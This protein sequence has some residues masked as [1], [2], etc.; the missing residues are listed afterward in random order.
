MQLQRLEQGGAQLLLQL[1]ADR[2]QH[3]VRRL[4]LGHPQMPRGADGV[5]DIVVG[6]HQHAR[7]RDRPSS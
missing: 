3:V 4:A 6:R 1:G 5:D 2:L 7:R